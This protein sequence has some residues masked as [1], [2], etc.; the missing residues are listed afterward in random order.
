MNTNR[1][2]KK[3]IE[4]ESESNDTYV[5]QDGK[6][7][8]LNLRKNGIV[9]LSD[10]EIDELVKEELEK[11]V[12]AKSIIGEVLFYLAPIPFFASLFCFASA[13][14]CAFASLCYYSF[15]FLISLAILVDKE[16]ILSKKR[17]RFVKRCI[18][19]NFFIALILVTVCIVVSH[20]LK[21]FMFL[22][23]VLFSIVTMVAAYI[24]I[25]NDNDND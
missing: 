12:K 10:D 6:A 9:S 23:S 15:S 24:C 1:L 21:G 11:T 7:V 17:E 13:F 25:N 4:K 19:I 3:A 20:G 2:V 8:L 18:M 5:K 14:S 16:G 22:S